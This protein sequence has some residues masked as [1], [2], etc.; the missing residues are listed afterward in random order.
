M[1]GLYKTR[2]CRECPH[3]II[4][5]IA[6]D[7]QPHECPIQIEKRQN[8]KA[9]KTKAFFLTSLLIADDFDAVRSSN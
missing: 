7:W 3:Q 6:C 4:N 8:R 5:G 1:T 2:T 9:S